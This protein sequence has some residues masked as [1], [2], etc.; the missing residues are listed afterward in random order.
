MTLPIF[1]PLKPGDVFLGEY[2]VTHLLGAGGM[3]AVYQVIDEQ[4][5]QAHFALKVMQPELAKSTEFRNR[6]AGEARIPAALASDHIVRVIR[7]GIDDGTGLPFILMELLNGV[8][9]G[10]RIRAGFGLPV[11]YALM[12]L[13]QAAR[14][15]DVIHRS[16]VVHRDLKPENMVVVLSDNHEPRLKI[17]DFGIAKC[18]LIGGKPATTLGVG[19]VQ[20][21]APEQM[22]GDRDIG[23]AA[24]LYSLA[25]VAFALL[26][27]QAYW[28][29]DDCTIDSPIEIFRKLEKGCCERASE[30][31]KRMDQYLGRGIDTWLPDGFDEWFAKASAFEPKERFRSASDM[32]EA[33]VALYRQSMSPTGVLPTGAA[34]LGGL[35]VAPPRQVPSG[36]DRPKQSFNESPGADQSF[37]EPRP[38][39]AQASPPVAMLASARPRERTLASIPDLP[40]PHDTVD[41]RNLSQHPSGRIV[42][43]SASERHKGVRALSRANAVRPAIAGLTLA[44]LVSGVWLWSA[45]GQ[46]GRAAASHERGVTGAAAVSTAATVQPQVLPS[47]EAD[48]AVAPPSIV[49]VSE[50]DAGSAGLGSTSS[51]GA[52]SKATRPPSQGQDRPPRRRAET[53]PPEERGKPASGLPA[54][55]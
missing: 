28:V 30:R 31:V 26:T 3:G 32:I 8:D 53:Q 55:H 14:T 2:T 33:L 47:V 39:V 45:A 52:L 40:V 16:G 9:L 34:L 23:P 25:H 38:E 4:G 11:E 21:E 48:S 20:Y 7:T 12:L 49:L 5:T 27:G 22:R 43:I 17:V 41:V 50:A 1:Q 36:A 44:V 6:F 10:K 24:D 42:P 19:T 29:N 18:I 54:Y 46:P 13:H 37:N 51:G 15:L 35:D